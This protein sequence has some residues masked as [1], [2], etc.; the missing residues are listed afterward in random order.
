MDGQK[1]LAPTTAKRVAN[2]F[3]LSD[4]GSE[5]FRLLVLLS[6]TKEAGESRVLR[7][8]LGRLRRYQN[9]QALAEARDAYYRAW[10][11]PAIPS[12]RRPRDSALTPSG[13]PKPRAPRSASRPRR[14][15]SRCWNAL[16]YCAGTSPACS[17]RSTFK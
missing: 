6:Q 9:V 4:D 13:L 3:G 1:S 8:R 15:R 5:Y 12:W 7:V 14:G 2:A 10:Y 17:A 16:G 11:F